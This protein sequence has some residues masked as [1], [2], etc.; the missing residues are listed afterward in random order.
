MNMLTRSKKR[1]RERNKKKKKEERKKGSQDGQDENGKAGKREH[2]CRD[3]YILDDVVRFVVKE[4]RIG[5]MGMGPTG[6]QHAKHQHG[7]PHSR[8]LVF[9]HTLSLL[10]LYYWMSGQT[11]R[12]QAL[13]NRWL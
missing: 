10:F 12:L 5:H 9:V 11:L 2:T 8:S 13:N 6:C 7:P 4:A 1:G 3:R